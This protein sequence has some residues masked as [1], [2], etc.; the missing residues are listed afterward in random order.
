MKLVHLANF[1]S[2]N[3]GNGALIHGLES[4]I[5]E[6]FETL[7]EWSR[8]SWDDYTFKKIDFDRQFLE[9]VNSSD[10][11]I[12]GGAVTFNGRD[13]N[14]RTGT[15]FELPFD[16]W[17]EITVPVVFYGLS[18]RHW[19]GQ[20][21][22]HL[23]RLIETI[24]RILRADNMLFSVRNDGTKAWL[25]QLTGID[26]SEIIEIPDPA[27]YV[28]PLKGVAYPELVE[29]QNNVMISFNDEDSEWRFNEGLS[30]E[31]ELNY[32]RDYVVG[33][34]VTAV[35]RLSEKY[36]DMNFILVPHYYDDYRMI[37]DFLDRLKPQIAHQRMV[38]TGLARVKDTK[39]FYGRYASS[40]LAIS[41]RVHSMSPCIGMGTPTI[42]F[43][44]QDRMTNFMSDIGLG[45]QF[46]NAFSTDSGNQ[47][48]ELTEIALDSSN[49]FRDKQLR[50]RANLRERS[51][52]FHGLIQDF[53]LG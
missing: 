19:P 15:R 46:V 3:I 25:K 30:I 21:Y 5:Q 22:H 12:V 9:R 4:A 13:Y 45:D 34:L 52:L 29:N 44:T 39:W 40:D 6:D 17:S 42:A 53:I 27:L 48:A 2:T 23:D 49:K 35:E 41:M 43:T 20:Q 8:E 16:L 31:N 11:L 24:E 32:S 26:S 47:L 51:R 38:S 28:Q 33:E 14:S 37:T 50:A 36:E 18:Y 1:N 7:I 10:G